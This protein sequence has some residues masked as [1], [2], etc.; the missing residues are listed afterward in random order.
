MKLQQVAAIE[1]GRN[2]GESLY[3]Y[4]VDGDGQKEM[5][6]RQSAG[7]LAQEEYRAIAP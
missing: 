4:D 1:V 6:F 5:L 7:L 3:F 2:G